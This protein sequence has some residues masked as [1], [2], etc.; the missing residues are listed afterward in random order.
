VIHSDLLIAFWMRRGRG[1][2]LHGLGP[3][4]LAELLIDSSAECDGSAERLDKYARQ[5]TPDLGNALPVAI[6]AVDALGGY[7][8]AL[9]GVSDAH[10]GRVAVYVPDSGLLLFSAWNHGQD[11]PIVLCLAS[12]RRCSPRMLLRAVPR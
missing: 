8:D 1:I 7:S 4:A 11:R 2:L 6:A 3:R 9:I 5:L 10:A 12:E